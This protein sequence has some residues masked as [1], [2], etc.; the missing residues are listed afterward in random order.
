MQLAA[1]A[2]RPPLPPMRIRFRPN[3]NL[4][5]SDQGALLASAGSGFDDMDTWTRTRWAVRMV[6][7]GAPRTI[8]GGSFDDAVAAARDIVA[9]D[10]RATRWGL[11]GRLQ[12]RVD[13]LAVVGAKDGWQLVRTDTPLDAFDDRTPGGIGRW[14][15]DPMEVVFRHG[16]ARRERL[17][18]LALVGATRTLDLRSTTPSGP[19]EP[20]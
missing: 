13:A 2:E 1:T 4:N 20:V 3:P 14:R 18:V 19:T 6:G 11:F 9:A 8:P 5:G 10:R 16:D 12:G 15:F 17:D 7:S